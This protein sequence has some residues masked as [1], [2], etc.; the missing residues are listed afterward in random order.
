MLNDA[1]DLIGTAMFLAFIGLFA[2][3]LTGAI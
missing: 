3:L 2:G 1:I